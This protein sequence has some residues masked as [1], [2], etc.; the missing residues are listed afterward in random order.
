MLAEEELLPDPKPLGQEV[1][2]RDV[3]EGLSLMMTQA[4]NHYQR[5]EHHCFM[6]GVTDHFAQDC[7][8]W[9]SFHMWQKEQLK[10]Q[11]IGSQSKDVNKLP[12]VVNA[13]VAS[14]RG[15]SLMIASGPTAH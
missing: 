9:E 14:M 11:G 10:S 7:P 13:C 2:E 1:P 8:H 15:M 12:K 4:M 3:I 6:C 5:E